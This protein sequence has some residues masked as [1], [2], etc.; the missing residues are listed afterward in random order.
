MPDEPGQSVAKRSQL[1]W[2]GQNRAAL[3]DNIQGSVQARNGEDSAKLESEPCR[4]VFSREVTTRTTAVP[5]LHRQPRTPPI[6]SARNQSRFSNAVRLRLQRRDIPNQLGDAEGIFRS[7]PLLP[8]RRK[9]LV[10]RRDGCDP[11]PHGRQLRRVRLD[12]GIVGL[13]DRFIQLRQHLV[14]ERRALQLANEAPLP[15]PGISRYS[16]DR[17]VGPNPVAL[18]PLIVTSTC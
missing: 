13:E 16:R 18:R 8:I 5:S 15:E 7:A 11:I 9:R 1:L 14:V 2:D 4:L 12:V 10:R 3:L 6:P 17:F